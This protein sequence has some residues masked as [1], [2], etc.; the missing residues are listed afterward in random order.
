MHQL[1][2]VLNNIIDVYM[3]WDNQVVSSLMIYVQHQLKYLKY[4][5]QFLLK[6]KIHL[7][8]LNEFNRLKR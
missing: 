1:I 8:I 6:R 5:V 3:F 7:L 4:K 2:L